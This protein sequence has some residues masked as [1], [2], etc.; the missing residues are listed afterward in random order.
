MHRPHHKAMA[1]AWYLFLLQAEW[2]AGYWMRTGEI[3]HLKIHILPSALN[4]ASVKLRIDCRAVCRLVTP[5]ERQIF[6]E[7]LKSVL[8]NTSYMWETFLQFGTTRIG[9]LMCEFILFKVSV[10]QVQL[11]LLEVCH[12]L[13]VCVKTGKGMYQTQLCQLRC[14]NDYIRQLNVS[15]PTG[16]L[17]VVFKRT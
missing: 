6:R 13:C 8:L 16:H 17:Q 14:F 10:Q 5:L 15:A 9:T 11:L 7:I 1:I 12:P 2:N 3:G 4:R